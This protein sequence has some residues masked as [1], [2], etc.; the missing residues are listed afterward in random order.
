M[1]SIYHLGI[2][3]GALNLII[4]NIFQLVQNQNSYVPREWIHSSF[5]MNVN[6]QQESK[7]FFIIINNNELAIV[8]QV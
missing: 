6:L 4:A 2:I 7:Y 8:G 3:F 5:K 1:I